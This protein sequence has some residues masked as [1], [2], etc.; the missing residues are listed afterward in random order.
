MKF[1]TLNLIREPLGQGF[2]HIYRSA[3]VMFGFSE[4][5]VTL[6]DIDELCSAANTRDETVNRTVNRTINRTMIRQLKQTHSDIL[7]PVSGLTEHEEVEGDGIILDR[8][9][10]A[11]VI[12]TADCTPLFLWSDDGVAGAVIHIGWRGLLKGIELRAIEHIDRFFPGASIPGLNAFLGPAIQQDCY[13]VGEEVY[14]EFSGKHYCADIF[15]PAETP[16]KYLLD[17]RKGIALSLQ[18]AGVSAAR[19]FDSGLCTYCE[20]DRFPSYRRLPG[21]GQRIYN[22]F[23]RK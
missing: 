15:R 6:G 14:L 3:S 23:L 7:K 16:G 20:K 8:P 9:A 13:E 12:R 21:S 11:G 2:V 22:F 5:G 18:R 17:V 1:Q 4:L 10:V 19:I